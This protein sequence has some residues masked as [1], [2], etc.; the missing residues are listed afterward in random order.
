MGKI[1][2]GIFWYLDSLFYPLVIKHTPTVYGVRYSGSGCEKLSLFIAAL[3]P[4]NA[5][6]PSIPAINVCNYYLPAYLGSCDFL[7]FYH[8]ISSKVLNILTY[9]IE[10]HISVNLRLYTSERI[11]SGIACGYL[12]T[13]CL[14]RGPRFI[15][16]LIPA[17]L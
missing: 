1:L 4:L 3:Q 6:W 10:L 12:S 8:E 9:L 5:P 11:N 16:I 17:F 7:L 14:V 2:C 15:F 13:I